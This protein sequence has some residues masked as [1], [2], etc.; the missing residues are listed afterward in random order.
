MSEVL[1]NAFFRS[2]FFPSLLS[3][4]FDQVSN[5]FSGEFPS[6]LSIIVIPPA[7]MKKP[8]KNS[9]LPGDLSILFRKS[10]KNRKAR[11]PEGG[12]LFYLIHSLKFE[13]MRRGARVISPG[14]PLKAKD[15]TS[16]R[17]LNLMRLPGI[18]GRH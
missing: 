6:V 15:G 10:R 18:D 11:F 3:T 4:P 17:L 16:P 5:A 12:E 8:T 13:S 1:R 14:D 7:D 9:S 2:G